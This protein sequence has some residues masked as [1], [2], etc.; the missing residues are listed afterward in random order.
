MRVF[1]GFD[2][3]GKI[4]NPVV[5]TGTFDG[6]HLGHKTILNRLKRLAAENDG[7]SV[8]ITFYPHPRKV[9]YP[10]TKGKNLKMI[11]TKEEKIE[12]LEE[13]GLDNLIIVEF[14]REFSKV[15]GR[16][17]IENYVFARLS[18]VVVVVGFNHHF[19]HNKEGD[20]AYLQSVSSEYGFRAEEIPEQ[21]VQ[22]ETVSSTEIRKALSE[23]YIQKANAYLDHYYFVS[24]KPSMGDGVA[25]ING[26]ARIRITIDDDE[27]MFPLSGSYAVSIP[28]DNTIK[29]GFAYI[30]DTETMPAEVDLLL[31]DGE[32]ICIKDRSRIRLNF[33]KRMSGIIPGGLQSSSRMLEKVINET[34]ELIF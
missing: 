13:A 17:F 25:G 23:G 1:Y 12:L 24:G 30:R 3:P 15:S 8:L 10:G 19:G 4:K 27:K 22:N 28:L 7:E 20:Y 11:S 34:K 18:P 6:V 2:K 21:E 26:D 9:L 29:R 16:E 14:T 33:H 31:F 5:T 32:G